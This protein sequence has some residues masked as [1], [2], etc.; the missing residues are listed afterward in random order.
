VETGGTFVLLTPAHDEESV[1]PITI[2]GV[3]AQS[4]RP[5]RWIIVDDA[6]TD[7]TSEIARSAAK[8]HPFITVMRR[9][10]HEGRSYGRKA[11]AI[12]A[13]WASVDPDGVEVVA[14]LDADG[15]LPPTV[16]ERAVEAFQKDSR[17]GLTGCRYSQTVNGRV[18]YDGGPAH[19]VPGQ[20]QIFRRAAWSAIGG[21][22]A[23]PRGGLDSNANVAVRA[24]GWTTRV[25]PGLVAI[26]LRP[27]GSRNWRGSLRAHRGRGLRDYDAGNLAWFEAAKCLKRLGERPIVVGAALRFYGYVH[28]RVTR[29]ERHTPERL[30]K[31]VRRE[32]RDRLRLAIRRQSPG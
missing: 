18:E 22:H 4:R 16:F 23:T 21:Y 1:L 9:E 3:L 2:A 24:E 26:H 19:Q 11:D 13:A 29:L 15:Q 27:E 31:Q 8:E 10:S 7:R 28:S 6:S 32:Q 25:L 20:V 14:C 17:L 12:N 30:V 5:D